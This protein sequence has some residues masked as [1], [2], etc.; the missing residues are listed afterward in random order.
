M[1]THIVRS[2][3]EF[4]S[5]L[6]TLLDKTVVSGRIRDGEVHVEATGTKYGLAEVAEQLMWVSTALHTSRRDDTQQSQHVPNAY[7]NSCQMEI[8]VEATGPSPRMQGSHVGTVNIR[9]GYETKRLNHEPELSHG[10]CW[11]RLFRN[12]E[13]TVGY[14][15]LPRKLEQRGLDIPLDMMADLI[16]AGRV[17]QFGLN[18]VIMGFSSLL[19]ATDYQDGVMMW[20]LVCNQD[21]T[22]ISFSDPRVPLVASPIELLPPAK[23][24]GRARH[25]VGWTNKVQNLT[26]TRRFQAESPDS[27][28]LTTTI[29]DI[30][31]NYSIKSSKLGPP[32]L[33]FAMERLQITAGQFITIGT[34]FIRGYREKPVQVEEKNF[35]VRLMNIGNRYFVLHDAGMR[36]TWLVDG[37]STVLHLLRCYL[38]EAAKPNDY[39][40]T[41]LNPFLKP[42]GGASSRGAA[43]NTLVH[44]ANL[45][46]SIHGTKGTLSASGLLQQLREPRRMRGVGFYPFKAVQR[47]FY[48]S[49]S[50]YVVITRIGER[51]EA[52]E[53]G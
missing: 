7:L 35:P 34:S 41:F 31:A 29:G 53:A 21:G 28:T 12:C 4:I 39:S 16:R 23:D 24:V 9:V 6:V 43:Y 40:S 49:L 47:P 37:L 11:H 48:T 18:L 8:R 26:G 25:I 45:K 50:K 17:T 19:Y 27:K 2:L 15:I 51:T 32:A 22:Q 52:L 33:D 13:I 36:K 10:S 14:P 3:V 44:D 20:H 1:I 38:A 30:G 42:I 5:N 46:L